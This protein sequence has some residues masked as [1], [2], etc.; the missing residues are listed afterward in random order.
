[1]GV[2]TVAVHSQE[3]SVRCEGA[4]K[5]GE[6]WPNTSASTDADSV[7][8]R[9]PCGGGEDHMQLG[10]GKALAPLPELGGGGQLHTA[11]SQDA[12]EAGPA[13]GWQRCTVTPFHRA[14]PC[15]WPSR[16]ESGGEACGAVPAQ[17]GQAWGKAG[18]RGAVL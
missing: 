3:H 14:Q 13:M 1:M 4:G 18:G 11:L 16:T 9:Q 2:A 15:F 6:G 5:A 17:S 7:K 8:P 12:G 10:E